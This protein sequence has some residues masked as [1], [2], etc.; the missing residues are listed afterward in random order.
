MIYFPIIEQTGDK[1]TTPPLFISAPKHCKLSNVAHHRLCGI[2]DRVSD[3]M[4]LRFQT[5]EE[6]WQK[7]PEKTKKELAVASMLEHESTKSHFG[8]SGHKPQEIAHTAS[9]G[10]KTG[11]QPYG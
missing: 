7:L 6:E 2:S 4:F 9:N 1:K 5:D 10:H 8:I 3:C 11:G